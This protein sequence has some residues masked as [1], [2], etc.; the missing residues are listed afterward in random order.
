LIYVPEKI[1]DSELKETIEPLFEWCKECE[2]N[3]MK[4]N[5]PIRTT[6]KI[7]ILKFNCF[8]NLK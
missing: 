1:E 3:A 2:T 7:K 6:K 4:K 8:E 5:F